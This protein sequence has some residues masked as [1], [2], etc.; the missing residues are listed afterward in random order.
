MS[1][2]RWGRLH[3]ALS[4]STKENELMIAG[5]HERQAPSRRAALE[6]EREPWGPGPSLTE[7]GF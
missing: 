1:R 2:Q 4:S 6:C 3:A 7:T 5:A